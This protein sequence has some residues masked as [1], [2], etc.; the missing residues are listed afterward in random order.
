M[1]T[2][3]ANVIVRVRDGNNHDPTFPKSSYWIPLPEDTA[4]GTTVM[5]IT[6][7]D[8]D[9]GS[10]AAT[11]YSSSSDIFTIHANDGTIKLAQRAEPNRKYTFAVTAYDNGK[12]PRSSVVQVSVSVHSVSDSAPTFLHSVYRKKVSED[13][14]V[15]ADVLR[16][17]AKN[18]AG[19]G[20]KL[21]YYLV[22]GDR[23]NQF[24]IDTD[25][26]WLSLRHSLDYERQK[27]YKLTV[28]AV[29]QGWSASMPELPAEVLELGPVETSNFS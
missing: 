10:N 8:L 11:T 16:V 22:G 29:Q 13:M 26:G 19:S 28:R 18:N 2:T 21:S 24:R 7:T 1:R 20:M 15:Q 17:E 9:S 23:R 25:T 14:N 6:A 12:P 3:T 5:K 27:E 4:A